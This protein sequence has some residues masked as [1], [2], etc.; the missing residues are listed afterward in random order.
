MAAIAVPG[1]ASAGFLFPHTPHHAPRVLITARGVRLARV[2]PGTTAAGASDVIDLGAGG[3]RVQSSA[4][5][6]QPGA[7]VSTPGFDA[8]SWLGV[9]NDDAGAPGT[10]VEALVQDGRCP[11]APGLQPVNQS[12]DSRHS[13][14]YSDTMKRC[15]G[16]VDRPGQ[17]GPMFAVPWWWRATFR[18]GASPAAPGGSFA[19]GGGQRDTLVINGVVGSADVWL[20][21][22]Q[23]ATSATVTGDYTRFTFNVTPDIVSGTNALA[24]KVLPN[25]PHKMFTLDDVDWNQVPADMNTGIQFPVQLQVDGVLSTG[26]A[27]VVQDDSAN[28]SRS[29]VTVVCDVTNHTGSAQAGIVTATITSPGGG[30]AV[31]VR[32]RVTVAGGATRQVAFTPAAFP[33][34]LIS[35]PR[36]WWPY[37]M[38]GQPL[39]TLATSVSVGG[40]VLNTT[41]ETFGIRTVTS[42]LTAPGPGMPLGARAFKIN[43]VPVVIRGGGWSPN[44][45]LHYSATDTAHQV[46][47]MKAMGVNMIRLEGHIMPAG[48]FRQMDAAGILVNAGYQCCDAWQLQNSH[49]TSNADYAILA[50]SALRIGEDLRNDP[51]VFSFQWSDTA[52]TRRQESVTLAAFKQAGFGDPVIS[53]ADYES[54]PQLGISGEKEGPYDWVP[55]TYWYDTRHTG[56]IAGN[57]GAW[58]YDAEQSAGDTVPTMDSLRRFMSASDL[59]SLWRDPLANQ[60]HADY[61]P[62]CEV[63]YSF[64]TLC[65]FDKAL[66]ARYGPPASFASYV[67]E[68]QALE[69]SDTQ[70]QF[71]AFIN[72]STSKPLPATG[73]VYWQMNKGWPSLLWNLY[74]SDGDQAGSYFGAQEANRPLHALYA[75]RN[76][77]VTL[78]NL[79]SK[80]QSGLSVTASVYNLAGK[81][82]DRRTASNIRLAGQQVKNDV[83]T[84]AVPATTAP[85]TPAGVYFVE[86]LLSRNGALV[87]RNVYWLSTQADVVNWHATFQQPVA[88]ISRYADLSELR[89]LHRATVSVTAST[90]PRPGP[91]G[92][93]RLTTVTLTNTSNAPTAGFLLR[94]DI[95]RGT[96]SGGIR[97]GDSELTSAIWDGNDVT[98]WPGE[99]QTV[100]VRYDSSDLQGATPVV[101]VSGW[102]IRPVNIVAAVPGR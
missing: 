64:G 15:Y 5:A 36:L 95:Y 101:R 43:N 99:S 46:A 83:L 9:A 70:A 53:S 22:H 45:F 38:G 30:T 84:P 80:T 68:A 42:Y 91:D 12:S 52:P 79:T 6:T 102:N 24:V 78:D 92:S 65:H 94:A 17:P 25:H 47:L 56:G 72:N 18:P 23:V 100:T 49:L 77:T 41:S 34:L 16:Y 20:N 4:V 71:E 98:L 19:G 58:G 13:V 7:Q 1:T 26:N 66:T 11:D 74:N 28:L 32:Q 61:E 35:H 88:V 59:R 57:G 2:L 60:Y 27:H 63:G 93:N 81:L 89:D 33:A 82:L 87:D 90:T 48:F 14:W 39:Y 3:W 21:G 55:P 85:P 31:T 40:T 86:L 73:T 51:S 97:P 44:L 62:Q 96:S 69:Y 67:E 54:S 75:L 37:Q 29:A 10:E 8:S 50:N 76:G